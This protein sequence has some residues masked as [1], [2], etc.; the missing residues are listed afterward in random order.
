MIIVSL[1]S[2][3]RLSSYNVY[4]KTTNTSLKIAK[5]NTKQQSCFNFKANQGLIPGKEAKEKDRKTKTSF[6]NHEIS[7]KR[8][9]SDKILK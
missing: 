3:Y 1:K 2:P 7:Q 5:L 9:Q 6:F 4:S 8:N